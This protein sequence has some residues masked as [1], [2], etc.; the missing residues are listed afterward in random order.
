[1]SGLNGILNVAKRAL[2]AQQVGIDV[3]N[4]N[5]SNA[6]TPGY[7]RQR[8][9]F[10]TAPAQQ[11][12]YGYLGGGVDVGSIQRLSNGFIN[13]QIWTT[14][15]NLGQATQQGQILNQI[16]ASLN[17]P[18]DT[19]L[20]AMITNFF[21]G[22]QSLAL[23]PEDSSSRNAVIQNAT[24]MVKTFNQLSSNLQQ[25]EKD[26]TPEIKSRV[27]HINEL[28]KEIWQSDQDIT[29]LQ[30]SGF[31]ANDALDNRDNLV[32]ELSK[33]ANIHVNQNNQ[34]S[35]SIDIGGTLVVSPSGFSTLT[36][37]TSGGQT[38]IFGQGSAR[39][40][41]V[42]SGE[43][44][45]I[46][47]MANTT[48]PKY[49][50]ELDSLASMIITRVNAVQSSGYGLG[51]PPPTGIDFFTGTDAG[52]IAINPAITASGNTI[53]A[54]GDGAPGDNSVALSLA[55]IANELSMGGGADTISQYYNGIVTDVGA[56]VQSV[57]NSQQSQN[58][59]LTQLQNQQISI[60]GVSTDEEMVNLIQ[61]QKGF[62]SAAKI[63]TIVN[64]MYQSLLDMITG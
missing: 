1:M 52:T 13:Q 32:G 46:L 48:I 8:V 18:S 2:M 28:T 41:D 40:I 57:T 21:G 47:Q 27:D 19:G 42:D 4:H 25:S 39:P 59:V 31:A 58:L 53:A 51:T 38:Q 60:S 29:R 37:A 35:L 17:E 10:E 20:G 12:S 5:V 36:V 44:G 26:L 45:G 64:D 3:T 62:D 14:N 49:S 23:N 30:A 9:N 16:Q 15:Y 11:E 43:L 50:S 63:I 56:S 7:S 33:L 34:G 54:S 6:S 22:F 24:S 61:F 55:A